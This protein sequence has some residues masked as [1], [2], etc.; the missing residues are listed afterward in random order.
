MQ[1]VSVKRIKTGQQNGGK[2]RN[3]E[4]EKAQKKNLEKEKLRKK[5]QLKEKLK[6]EKYEKK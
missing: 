5:A 2:K 3:L 1:V 4:K 6:K